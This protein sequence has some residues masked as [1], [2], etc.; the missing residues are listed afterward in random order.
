MGGPICQGKIINRVV[1]RLD[2]ELRSVGDD[3]APALH[4]VC[5]W[6]GYEYDILTGQHPS[7]PNIKLRGVDVSESDG[8]ISVHL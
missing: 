2:D 3:F 7:A 6:H 8:E 5:P 4:V 1:E